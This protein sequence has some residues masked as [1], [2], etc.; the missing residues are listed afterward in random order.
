ERAALV[1]SLQPVIEPVTSGV[2]PGSP[3]AA[4]GI[5]PGDRILE[6]AG[7]PVPS[8]QRLVAIIQEH[9][10]QPVDLVIE[11]GGVAR[12]VSVTP[13]AVTVELP[14]GGTREIGRIGI[15]PPRERPGPIGALAHGV[16]RTWDVSATILEF[17]GDL[18]TG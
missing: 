2:E 18:V 6:A 9:P 7:E 13:A 15:A 17:L 4:A 11:R 12:T 16:R 8:W 3:A 14:E 5:Q 10:G 1:L